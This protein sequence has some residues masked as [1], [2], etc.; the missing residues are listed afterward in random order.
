MTAR[1]LAR[2]PSSRDPHTVYEVTHDPLTGS[3]MCTCPGFSFRGRCKHVAEYHEKVGFDED[4]Y[5]P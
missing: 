1:I 5:N 3:L 4:E 2:V